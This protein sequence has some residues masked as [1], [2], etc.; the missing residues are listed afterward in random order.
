MGTLIDSSVLIAGERRQL[1]LEATFAAHPEEDFALS[2]ITASELLHGV[3]RAKSIAQRNRRE[4]FVEGILARFPIVAFDLIAARLHARLSAGL[5]AQGISIGPHDLII[6]TTAIANG[7]RVATRDE[8][9]F[10]HI[11]GLSLLRW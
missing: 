2:A 6:A 11:P 1:D 7:Y 9:S 4:V 8:R 10:P 3:H 5:A